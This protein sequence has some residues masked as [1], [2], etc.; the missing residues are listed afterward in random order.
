MRSSATVGTGVVL[1]C[2]LVLSGCSS[3]SGDS[4]DTLQVVADPVAATAPVSPQPAAAPA[5]TVIA[6]PEV[7]ALAADPATGTLAVAVPD[8]VLLYRAADLAAAPLRVPVAGRAE[9]LR[10]SGGVLLATLPA[11]GQVARIALP[12]GEVS[13]LTVAGQPAGAVVEGDRT[14]VAVRDR[15][16]V[17][18]FSGGQLTKTIEGQLYSADDVLQ[19]GGN[20]VV[21]D[22]LRTALFSVDV[23]GGTMAEGLR[24]GDGATNAVADSFGRVLVVDTR[25][26]ALLAFST[27]PL[28]LRQRYPVPGGAY[29]LAYDAQRA[30]A[31]VTLTERNEV[32][33]FDVRGGEP[34][35]KYRFPTVRQP[36]SVTVEERSGRVV[37]GSAAGEGVQVIQS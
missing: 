11:A 17:D 31:W 30:L 16:A 4:T 8:A 34:V 9:H 3:K 25:A 29:G 24:A 32:V 14:L 18:V 1:V 37:V 19:A 6:S 23:D 36:D 33:G 12:G 5:G 7:T 13:T 15:K 21:L 20:T 27:G 10:V 22:E 2:A 26:G 35:E 28:L